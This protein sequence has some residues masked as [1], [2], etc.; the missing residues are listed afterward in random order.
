[1]LQEV[2][3]E[4]VEYSAPLLCVE[5]EEDGVCLREEPAPCDDDP[6]ALVCSID[7]RQLPQK[8]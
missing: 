7:T 6:S 8:R 3:Y 5:E 2:G 4:W 1:M